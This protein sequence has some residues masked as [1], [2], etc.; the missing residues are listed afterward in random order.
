M[1]E[2]LNIGNKNLVEFVAELFLFDT[3][4]RALPCRNIEPTYLFVGFFSF[5]DLGILQVYVHL[6]GGEHILISSPNTALSYFTV[7]LG[8]FGIEYMLNEYEEAMSGIRVHKRVENIKSDELQWVVSWRTKILIFAIGVI[9]MYAHAIFNVGIPERITSINLL[10]TWQFVLLPIMIEF[11]LIYI[12]IHIYLPRQI[13]NAD[14]DMFFYDPRNMGGFAPIGTLLKRSYY[15]YTGALLLFF[16]FAYGQVLLSLGAYEPGLFDLVFFSSAWFIGL[17]SIGYSMYTV[18]QVM[19]EE[20]E[21][22][23]R[24]IEDEMH[25][26][27]ENPYDINNSTVEDPEKL[28]DAQRRLEQ[29]RNTRVY[30]ATFT[31][32]SQI[33]ISVLLPQLLQLT[34]QATL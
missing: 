14:V 28:N 20:K 8:V 13:K 31:M 4:S 21:N 25:E 9:L 30:P 11:A 23:I 2:D 5:L 29:V 7:I 15:L 16:V 6:T 26:A 17:L 34:V 3:L 18:H 12:S 22:R 1:S 10:F 24:E 32:W 19:S 27:L 33:G